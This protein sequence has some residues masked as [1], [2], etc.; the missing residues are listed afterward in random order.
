MLADICTIFQYMNLKVPTWVV[1]F[2]CIWHLH[3]LCVISELNFHLHRFP[4][5][6]CSFHSS[7][8]N[9]SDIWYQYK[10][11]WGS[12]SIN[13]QD[14]V[15]Q[16]SSFTKASMTTDRKPH[17]NAGWGE[18]VHDIPLVTSLVDNFRNHGLTSPSLTWNLKMMVSKRNLLFQGAMLRFHVKLWEGS[19]WTSWGQFACFSFSSLLALFFLL[20]FFLNLVKLVSIHTRWSYNK[21]NLVN[22]STKTLSL[23]KELL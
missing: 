4:Q 2:S 23:N 22:T 21:V 10:A 1:K 3:V 16:G 20:I 17:L 8:E 9:H 18:C 11:W 12:R 5:F 19:G 13:G 7:G 6:H 15:P 14:T